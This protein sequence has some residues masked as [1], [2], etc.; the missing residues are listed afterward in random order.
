MN[1]IFHNC[2][3]LCMYIYMSNI[4]IYNYN[5]KTKSNYIYTLY[6]YLFNSHHL[7]LFKPYNTPHLN[8]QGLFKGRKVPILERT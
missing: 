4:Y 3:L 8:F 5:N 1:H 2:H 7:G 6:T